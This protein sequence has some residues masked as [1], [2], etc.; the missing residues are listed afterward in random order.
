MIKKVMLLHQPPLKLKRGVQSETK[1]K[2]PRPQL[3]KLKKRQIKT[4][5]MI[6]YVCLCF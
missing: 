4:K 3:V 6:I 1:I 5:V 2:E